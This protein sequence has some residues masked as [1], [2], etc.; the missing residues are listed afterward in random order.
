MYDARVTSEAGGVVYRANQNVVEILLVR[1]R[2][3]AWIFPK[4]HL[5]KGE[6]AAE[7][8][9]RETREEAGV[10]GELVEPLEALQF[11]SGKEKV[12]VDYFLVRATGELP[13]TEN[14]QRQWLPMVRAMQ[15]LTHDDARALLR[16]AAPRILP[17][18]DQ[19]LREFLLAE[20]EHC[21]DSMLR[22]EESGESRV[23]VFVG[24]AAVVGAVLP[25]V[26]DKV[27]WVAVKV[28]LG[29]LLGFGWLTLLRLIRRNTQTDT[30]KNDLA[31]LRRCFVPSADDPRR[32]LLPFDPHVLKPREASF[33]PRKIGWLETVALVEAVIAGALAAVL[34]LDP[35]SRALSMGAG[36]ALVTWCLAIGTA[37]LA[38]RSAAATSP[39]R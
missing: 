24:L 32:L 5:E 37:R 23:N 9:L 19:A 28:A 30:Y 35:P 3:K 26:F 14:R 31:I 16:R 25:M 21:A 7:A 20:L 11:R 12:R 17:E 6:S 15:M 10:E 8:A 18:P 27:G 29:I 13:P 1:A 38:Y 2:D 39:R 22:N 4:G 36:A 34:V 33:L